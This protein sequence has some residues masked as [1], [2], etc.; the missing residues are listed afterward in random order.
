MQICFRL[1][2]SIQIGTGH[3]MRS[4]TLA[5]QL[6]QQG[7]AVCFA[8]RKDE[9]QATQF[10]RERCFTVLELPTDVDAP[11]VER[12]DARHFIQVIQE[13][14][15]Q[16]DWVI[17][18]HYQLGA[19]WEDI[20]A[21]ELGVSIAV[22]DDLANRAHQCDILLDQNYYS[23]L[24]ERY[25][26]LVPATCRQLLGP[27][28]VILR[29]EFYR[30]PKQLTQRNGERR[31]LIFFGGSDPTNETMKALQAVQ[32]LQDREA[33]QLSEW[34]VDVIVGQANPKRQQIALLCKQIDAHFHCQI[35]YLAELMYQATF[36]LGAGGVTMWERCYVGLPS[37]VTIVAENQRQS[38]LDTARQGAIKLL[39][40]HEDISVADY[41]EAVCWAITNLAELD[42]IRTAGQKLMN[43]QLSLKYRHDQDMYIHPFVAA[44]VGGN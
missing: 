32:E 18:D 9:G 14:K 37:I 29:P 1:D 27:S 44:I 40:W 25:H 23:N 41:R 3:L 4:L 26:G 7:V 12:E 39:G 31:I 15:L 13:M 33:M 24:Q 8:L 38:V 17:V 30:L 28:Y 34:Q 10:L 43:S 22:V 21:T 6:R 16:L 35:D 5:E 2:S 19:V 20:V 11:L 42:L 36:S